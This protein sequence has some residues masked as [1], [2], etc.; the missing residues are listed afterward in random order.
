MIMPDNK[1]NKSTCEAINFT[2]KKGTKLF[3]L[4]KTILY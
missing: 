3:S 2:H 4:F 1:A